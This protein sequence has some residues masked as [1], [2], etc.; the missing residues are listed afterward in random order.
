[1]RLRIGFIKCPYCVSGNETD[2]LKED[3]IDVYLKDGTIKL[4]IDKSDTQKL[5][6]WIPIKFCPMCGRKL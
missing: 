5:I 2:I 6:G 3:G 1:M 4:T